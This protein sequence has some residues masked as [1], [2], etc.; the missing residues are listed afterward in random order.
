MLRKRILALVCTVALLLGVGFSA[1]AA[2]PKLNSKDFTIKIGGKKLDL[3]K[4]GVKELEKLAGKSMKAGPDKYDEYV[5]LS[6]DGMSFVAYGEDDPVIRT[7]TID[8]KSKAK[9]ARGV[10]IGTPWK[11]VVNA[12]GDPDFEEELKNGTYIGY[13]NPLKKEPTDADY[14]KLLKSRPLTYYGIYIE[15]DEDMCVRN[16]MFT[17][18]WGG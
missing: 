10:G 16:I 15:F 6:V 9:T 3:L 8:G 13:Y 12:Y 7:V 2:S 4:K 1:Q 18:N 17:D 14:D 11:E 5:Y